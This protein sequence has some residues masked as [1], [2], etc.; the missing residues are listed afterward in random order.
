MAVAPRAPRDAHEWLSFEDPAEDR[1]WLVDVTFLSS[2]WRCIYGSGCQGVLTEPA[3]EQTEGCCSYGAHFTDEADV[4]RVTA[5]AATLSGEQW[6]FRSKGRRKAG[7]VK[8][9]FEG[10]A[11]TRLVDGA[12]IF[13]N[14]PGHPGGAGCALHRAAIDG[15]VPPRKLKPDVC[16]QLPLRRRGRGLGR[17]ARDELTRRMGASSLGS[18]R[19]ALRL[20][21]H[22]GTLGLLQ[23]RTRLPVASRRARR[24]GRQGGLRPAGHLPQSP[25]RKARA[26]A[27]VAG[28]SHRP[29]ARCQPELGVPGRLSLPGPRGVAVD[30]VVPPLLSM[31]GP[32]KCAPGRSSSTSSS[33]SDS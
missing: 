9:D 3:P 23:A 22:R 29:R 12:C 4:E 27:A 10:V 33:S 8:R 13:L 25:G 18:G 1:T 5:A 6:Q 31:S 19:C 11:A 20:V 15:G 32:E 16:W 7:A 26:V 2:R 21:V 30:P 28:A 24:H 14:R 17:R